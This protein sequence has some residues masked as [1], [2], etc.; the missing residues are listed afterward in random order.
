MD[1][2]IGTGIKGK[3]LILDYLG[4]GLEKSA[5]RFFNQYDVVELLG[6]YEEWGNQGDYSQSN[7]ELDC[8]ERQ[9]RMDYMSYLPGDILVK[10]D[11]CSM[12]HSLELRAPFL[13]R[14]L[15]EYAFSTFRSVECVDKRIGKKPLIRL[16]K[17]LLTED[18]DFKRK[19]GFSVPFA[20]M[21][22]SSLSELI[23]DTFSSSNGLLSRK[24]KLKL[25]G[26][27]DRGYS[28]S[29]RIFSILMLELTVAA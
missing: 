28:H 1:R 5:Y 14:E 8:I 15:V 10:T 9:M 13:S 21:I 2:Y 6:S 16:G 19:A 3:Q 25:L 4:L 18:F 11:R 17:K 7:K 23:Y 26:E 12:Q 29:E 24:S 22:R 27:F 20:D